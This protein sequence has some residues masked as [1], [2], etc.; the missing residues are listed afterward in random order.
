MLYFDEEWHVTQKTQ[1]PLHQYVSVGNLTQFP[2]IKKGFSFRL[3][4]LRRNSDD[5]SIFD[6]AS[7][8][9]DDHLVLFHPRQT[10]IHKDTLLPTGFKKGSQY[11]YL[12]FELFCGD[13]YFKHFAAALAA[14]FDI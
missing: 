5:V 13:K 11:F 4:N 6:D 14:F 12:A 10:Y 3:W 1:P 9:L 2:G 8:V 7:N